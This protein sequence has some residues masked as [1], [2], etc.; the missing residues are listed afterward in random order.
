M[1]KYLTL[2]REKN[3]KVTPQRLEIIKYLDEKRVHPDADMI[4]TE[5]KSKNPSLSRTTVY[6]TLELL[7]EHNVVTGLCISGK[8]MRYCYEETIHHHF[9]CKECGEII[10]FDF[11]VP[12]LEN[13]MSR[14]FQVDEVHLYSKG[15]C[16]ECAKKTVDGG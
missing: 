13:L 7:M 16:K 4:F 11:D 2:L 5:L 6:N 12:D 3:L 14:G 8:E 9:L 1:E 15:L 10:G